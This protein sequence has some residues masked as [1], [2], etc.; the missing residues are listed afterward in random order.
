M[1]LWV[2]EHMHIFPPLGEGFQRIFTI[3]YDVPKRLKNHI[4]RN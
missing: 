2:E 3:I 4:L 1:K